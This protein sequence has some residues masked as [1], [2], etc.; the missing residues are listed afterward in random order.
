MTISQTTYDKAI[1][2]ARLD[3]FRQLTL[4]PSPVVTTEPHAKRIGNNIQELK[5]K[6]ESFASEIPSVTSQSTVTNP[7]KLKTVVPKIEIPKRAPNLSQKEMARPAF[8]AGDSNP[9]RE[10]PKEASDLLIEQI[11]S[12]IL[13]P[14]SV[15]SQEYPDHRIFRKESS[16]QIQ[17]KRLYAKLME[18]T[19]DNKAKCR[20]GFYLAFEKGE[21]SWKPMSHFPKLTKTERKE[22]KLALENLL[23]TLNHFAD[24]QRIFEFTVNDDIVPL[25]FLLLRIVDYPIETPKEHRL[26][27]HFLNR[28]K[29]SHLRQSIIKFI[30]KCTYYQPLEEAKHIKKFLDDNYKKLSTLIDA[31][32]GLQ[33]ESISKETSEIIELGLERLPSPVSKP[34]AMLQ[35]EEKARRATQRILNEGII[36]PRLS[37][38]VEKRQQHM[39]EA[40]EMFKALRTGLECM[41]A[42]GKNRLVKSMG[43]S[44]AYNQ[45]NN[46]EGKAY[47]LKVLGKPERL[48]GCY[49]ESRITLLSENLSDCKQFIERFISLHEDFAQSELG[50]REYLKK[51]DLSETLK[52]KAKEAY[53]NGDYGECL[54]VIF[55]L[56]GITAHLKSL[57]KDLARRSAERLASLNVSVKLEQDF[58]TN[59][60]TKLSQVFTSLTVEFAKLNRA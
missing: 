38:L 41:K 49:D 13:S 2:Q 21:Y 5:N 45:L 23:N 43:V 26:T 22:L 57:L 54:R 59:D 28:K 56:G 37:Q 6:Y 29:N 14:I 27:I 40:N 1:F 11:A 47:L 30:H 9:K 20:S 36:S 24:S 39:T 4:S 34:E 42:S 12:P 51:C 10:I 60:W 46:E 15:R 31:L 25:H 53:R 50:M 7:L 44:S 33:L 8:P 3:K 18:R 35:R 52:E 48:F 58:A 17:L 16:D 55:H 32:S 19:V